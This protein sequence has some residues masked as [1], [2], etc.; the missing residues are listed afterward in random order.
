MYHLNAYL[1]RVCNNKLTATPNPSS[2][3]TSSLLPTNVTS[4]W[5]KNYISSRSSAIPLLG[6]TVLDFL[7][8]MEI[9]IIWLERTSH[10]SH[11]GTKVCISC[12]WITYQIRCDDWR[13]NEL[14]T[15]YSPNGVL[16]S[17]RRR[18]RT[19]FSAKGL[20][21]KTQLLYFPMRPQNKY[22]CSGPGLS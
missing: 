5:D 16:P 12:R 22:K 18:K 14:H 9:I 2:C 19:M 1:L 8:E 4:I 17:P 11:I 15:E 10:P 3:Y 7:I 21:L 20:K 6:A 13:H